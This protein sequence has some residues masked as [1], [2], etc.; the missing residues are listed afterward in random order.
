MARPQNSA[1]ELFCIVW[2]QQW[3][4]QL[5]QRL[6][7]WV[8]QVI[9]KDTETPDVS[10]KPWAPSEGCRGYYQTQFKQP[11]IS[12]NIGGERPSATTKFALQTADPRSTAEVK[13]GRAG[14]ERFLS[15]RG[16]RAQSFGESIP[17]TFMPQKRPFPTNLRFCDRTNTRSPPRS[18]PAP[19]GLLVAV[20]FCCCRCPDRGASNACCEHPLV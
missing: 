12:K 13:K 7:C 14:R 17:V 19:E 4:L 15:C 18:A 6:R 3:L 2:V 20:A 5:L 8:R 1:R 11:R 10:A 9:N 16:L